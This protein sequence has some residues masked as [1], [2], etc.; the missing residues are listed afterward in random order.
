MFSNILQKGI[1]A[2]FDSE[3][4]RK[5]YLTNALAVSLAIISL[6]IMVNDYFF[7][8]NIL[9][10]HRRLSVVLVLSL[11]PFLN[12]KGYLRISKIILTIVPGCMVFLLPI[13]LKDFFPGQLLWFHYGTAIM[14]AIP[15]LVFHHQRERFLAFALFG[16]YFIL[17]ATIDQ[18]LFHFNPVSYEFEYLLVNFTD[19]KI[20]P[21]F[22]SLTL[23]VVI[24]WFNLINVHYASRLKLAN[25]ELSNTNEELLSKSE[26]LDQLNKNLARLVKERA[27]IIAA[28]DRQIIEYANLNAHKVR[29]PLARILGLLSL[30]DHTSNEEELKKLIEKMDYSASEL[31]DI[32]TEMNK[33]LAE[34][35]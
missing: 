14:S 35:D 27:D 19:Y 8:G 25:E 6:M 10:G 13:I 26:Q 9:A 30:T 34:A 3:Q 21:I 7:A 2:E 31:N 28:K 33:V 1:R 22:V 23:G 11:I 24:Y 16:F 5:I 17:T 15:F 12:G 20:P 32:I 4:R 29:G 18:L